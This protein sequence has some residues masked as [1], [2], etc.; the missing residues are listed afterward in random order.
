[1]FLIHFKEPVHK[2]HLLMNGIT[3]EVLCVLIVSY[4][5]LHRLYYMFVFFLP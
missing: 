3:L 2:S 5:V 4:S 1:M